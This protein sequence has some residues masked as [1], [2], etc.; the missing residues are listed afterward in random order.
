MKVID[1]RAGF[2]TARILE[3]VWVQFRP[4]ELEWLDEGLANLQRDNNYT[5]EEKDKLANLRMNLWRLK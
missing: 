3:G 4:K 2:G 5:T 1:N